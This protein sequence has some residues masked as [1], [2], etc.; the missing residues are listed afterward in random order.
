M[1]LAAV[2]DRASGERLLAAERLML[3]LPLLFRDLLLEC[4]LAY[5]GA[6]RF[7]AAVARLST[8]GPAVEAA[9]R[10]A[11][12]TARAGGLASSLTGMSPRSRAAFEANLAR[13]DVKV[14][15]VAPR[16][17]AAA[18]TRVV[19]GAGAPADRSHLSHA[20]PTLAMDA[21]GPGWEG[22][23]YER[24]SHA[25]FVPGALAPP[26]GDEMVVAIRV[27]RRDKPLEAYARVSR[28]RLQEEAAAGMPAGFT[29]TLV[30]PPRDLELALEPRPVEAPA[31]R[32]APRYPVRLPVSVT[33][34]EP[35]A[36]APEAAATRTAAATEAAA[37]LEPAPSAAPGGPRT[38]RIEY[39]TEQELVRD[40]VENL[41][42]GGAFIRT[43]SPPPVG[44]RLTLQ[45]R[46]P[47][48]V[49]L[50]A[51]AEVV[52]VG[53]QGMGVKFELDEAADQKLAAV[54]ARIS[55]RPRRALVVDD[56]R[57]ARR[58]LSDALES[59]GF[60]VV[61]ARDGA[62]GLHTIAEQLLTLDVLVTDA[63]MPGMDGE[64][65]VRTIRR[66]GGESEL[67]ILV[68][69]AGADAALEAAMASAGADAVV[70]KSVGPELVAQ[71]AD[72]AL[73]RKR[74][75]AS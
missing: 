38:A 20:L 7:L 29:L 17:L 63:R 23:T 3:S 68:A 22:V 69:S 62:E 54:I 10:L 75:A 21:G 40:W 5:Q 36:R 15:R 12:W 65:F 71:A 24:T 37:G 6:T 42:Q 74:L 66:Q 48:S 2:F 1:E 8:R 47:G 39:A 11:F 33:P 64:T 13:F 34:L 19:T 60:E 55:A 57:L 31:R 43:S 73:E 27:P 56:D 9:A 18:V 52:F 4:D 50:E 26:V 28:V 61:T 58:M 67:A 32:A 72:A 46:L 44:T 35:P 59:R 14:L 30:S 70:D 53:N 51:P 41:S 45:M 16:D 25:L 49:E